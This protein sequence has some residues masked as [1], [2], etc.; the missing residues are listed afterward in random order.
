MWI[1]HSILGLCLL[2]MQ[3]GNKIY[4]TCTILAGNKSE[5]TPFLVWRD[6]KFSRKQLFLKYCISILACRYKHYTSDINQLLFNHSILSPSIYGRKEDWLNG[7][8]EDNIQN[9]LV[10]LLG[11]CRWGCIRQQ[12]LCVMTINK[13]P[14][15][16]LLLCVPHRPH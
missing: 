9:G 15:L 3:C 16:L 5:I 4:C 10:V 2:K 6:W 11:M 14:L 12:S 8:A 7:L 13:A 1:E